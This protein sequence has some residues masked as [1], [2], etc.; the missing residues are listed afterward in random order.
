MHKKQGVHNYCVS[1]T[2]TSG[3]FLFVFL[4]HWGGKV[5]IFKAEPSLFLE[6]CFFFFF[7]SGV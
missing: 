4:P 3:V 1:D 5:E 7:G 2:A 6:F